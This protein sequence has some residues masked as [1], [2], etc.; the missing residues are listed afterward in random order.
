MIKETFLHVMINVIFGV[1]FGVINQRNDD[2]ST[3]IDRVS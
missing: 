1:M 3:A 2:S